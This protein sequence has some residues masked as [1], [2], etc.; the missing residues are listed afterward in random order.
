MK[1]NDT[2]DFGLAYEQCSVGWGEELTYLPHL[3]Y[4]AMRLVR[5]AS[6]QSNFVPYPVAIV[7]HD[8]LQGQMRS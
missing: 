2:V 4:R 8:P 5:I 1:K 3:D 6:E 7:P